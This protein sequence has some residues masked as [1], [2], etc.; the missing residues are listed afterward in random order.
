MF[1][2]LRHV[3]NIDSIYGFKCQI[4]ALNFVFET[5]AHKVQKQI[6]LNGS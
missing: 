6:L 1:T 2:K 5:N 4:S 3:L